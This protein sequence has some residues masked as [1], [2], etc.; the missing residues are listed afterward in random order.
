MIIANSNS[1]IKVD[2]FLYF[3]IKF[4]IITQYNSK[5]G[6]KMKEF[7]EN[8]PKFFAFPQK[9]CKIRLDYQNLYKRG[10]YMN[11]K[12]KKGKIAIISCLAFFLAI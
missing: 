11:N 12:T 8:L 6:L 9:K 3:F 4:K 5:I 7:H 1:T 2:F 10:G